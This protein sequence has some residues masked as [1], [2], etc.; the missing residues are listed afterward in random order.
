MSQA[1]QS[2]IKPARR[3]ELLD[4]NWAEPLR[5]GPVYD[6]VESARHQQSWDESDE[7][8]DSSD[9]GARNK[10]SNA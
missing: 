7:K 2:T 9:D 4:E 1:S 10:A 3:A 5:T 8:A 6:Q